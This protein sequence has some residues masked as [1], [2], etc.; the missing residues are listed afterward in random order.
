MTYNTPTSRKQTAYL[1][2][3]LEHCTDGVERSSVEMA[4][5]LGIGSRS[6]ITGILTRLKQRLV[7]DRHPWR[8]K[9]RIAGQGGAAFWKMERNGGDQAQGAKD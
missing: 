5:L 8:L 6:Q 3:L 4:D 9:K 1:E 2:R 7:I